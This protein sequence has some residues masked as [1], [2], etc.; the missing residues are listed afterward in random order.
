[1]ISTSALNFTSELAAN[2]ARPP[3]VVMPS[4]DMTVEPVVS[5][6]SSTST[7]PTEEPS[8]ARVCHSVLTSEGYL[9]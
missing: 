2:C 4:F 9:W 8:A 7:A 5:G 3:V 6:S 1:M